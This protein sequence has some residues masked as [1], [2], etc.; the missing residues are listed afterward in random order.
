MS[1]LAY[2]QEKQQR[3]VISPEKK[4][5]VKRG[6]PLHSGKRSSLV[7]FAIAVLSTS[8]FIVSKAYAAYQSN[9]EVQQLEEKVSEKNKQIGDLEKTVADLSQPRA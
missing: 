4:V 1:N 8:M 3:P 2:Q 7:L 9:I 6:L 5:I